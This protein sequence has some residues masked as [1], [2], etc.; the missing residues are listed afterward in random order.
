MFILLFLYIDK[1]AMK[2]AFIYIKIAVNDLLLICNYSN[3][4]SNNKTI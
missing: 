2:L 3:L 4:M 1:I